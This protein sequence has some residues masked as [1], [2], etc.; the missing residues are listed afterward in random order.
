MKKPQIP[1]EICGFFNKKSFTFLKPRNSRKNSGGIKNMLLHLNAGVERLRCIIRQ[2]GHISLH[3]NLSG[4]HTGIHIVYRTTG[5]SSTGLQCLAPSF[6]TRER[7]Q[8]SRMDIKNTAGESLQKRSLHQTHE[9]GKANHVNIQSLELLGHS[10]LNFQRKL[11]LIATT[12]H[13][14]RRHAMLASSLKD[15]GIR[16]IR[17]DDNH[18]CI[19]ATILDGIENRLAITAGAGP[20]Y[21]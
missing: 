17:E 11:I 6:H 16:L 13:H 8:K 21:C 12:I 5:L 2:N 20:K 19:Q 3:E 1:K 4:I 15:V 18:L 9:A 14:F 7:R 10:S